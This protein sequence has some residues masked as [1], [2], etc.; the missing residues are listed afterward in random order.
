MRFSRE[1]T[2]TRVHHMCDVSRASW[3][4]KSMRKEHKTALVLYGRRDDNAVPTP[5]PGGNR[6]RK[7]RR[8]YPNP[9]ENAGNFAQEHKTDTA[10]IAETCGGC[11]ENVPGN[12]RVMS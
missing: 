7:T 1:G 10:G 11:A 5:A 2:A 12:V 9:N 3:I 8:R 6:N 4:P